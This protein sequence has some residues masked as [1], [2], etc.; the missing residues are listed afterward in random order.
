MV[1]ELVL[2]EAQHLAGR[3]DGGKG[4]SEGSLVGV[5]DAY[6]GIHDSVDVYFIPSKVVGGLE[7]RPPTPLLWPSRPDRDTHG[8]VSA[9]AGDAGGWGGVH[10]VDMEAWLGLGGSGELGDRARGAS[11]CRRHRVYWE[12]D[13]ADEGE[14]PACAGDQ[15]HLACLAGRMGIVERGESGDRIDGNDDENAWFERSSVE[16]FVIVQPI[17]H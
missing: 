16:R 7:W 2:I 4:G 11:L 1:L 5:R 15:G 13:G 12:I 8:L 3:E 14:V 17:S 10:K 9:L 6:M